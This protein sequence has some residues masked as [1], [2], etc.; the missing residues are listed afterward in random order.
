MPVLPWTRLADPEPGR[1][2][3]V[4]A[5]RLP[6]R[7]YR[8]IPAFLHASRAVRAQ[9]AATKGV[10]GYSLDAK[11]IAKTFWTLSAWE[12][13]ETLRR[14]SQADPHWSQI[15]DIRP[16]MLASTFVQW[17]VAGSELPPK[18]TDARRRVAASWA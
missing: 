9:L 14:F 1:D 18:W 16:Y 10:L 7:R 17:T 11:P 8:N 6:L 3:V 4:L 2:Y 5:S 15:T 13:E 12:D